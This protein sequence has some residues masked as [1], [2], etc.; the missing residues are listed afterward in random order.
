MPTA[1]FAVAWL[2]VVNFFAAFPWGPA[3]AAAAEIVPAPIR[4]QGAA[5]YFFV[6][7]LVSGTLGPTAVAFFTD[8]V[9]HDPQELRYALVVVNVIG[10]LLTMG[11]LWFG[12]P[13]YRRTALETASMASARER[14]ATADRATEN[15]AVDGLRY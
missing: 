12:M 6:L 7:S 4:T 15:D 11:L 5:L 8:S 13:A 3:A 14:S 2:V 9:F 10:M 1:G